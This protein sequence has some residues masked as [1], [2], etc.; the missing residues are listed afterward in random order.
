M[1]LNLLPG[2]RELRAPLAAGYLWLFAGWL[3]LHG[4][5]PQVEGAKSFFDEFKGVGSAAALTFAAYLIGSFLTDLFGIVWGGARMLRIGPIRGGRS[6]PREIRAKGRLRE[7]LLRMQSV[8][9]LTAEGA[10]AVDEVC[11]RT[12]EQVPAARRS[13]LDRELFVDRRYAVRGPGGLRWILG[14]R[15]SYFPSDLKVDE[16]DDAFALHVAVALVDELD[17]ARFRLLSEQ[18]DLFS[19]VDRLNAEGE[20]RLA[21]SAPLAVLACVL[22][23]MD[24]FAWFLALAPIAMLVILG[25]NRREESGDRLVYALRAEK[26]TTPIL[27]QIRAGSAIDTRVSE[28]AAPAITA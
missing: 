2:L 9:P 21:V 7:R 5:V 11:K 22:G 26:V 25:F 23:F 1:L 18:K 6:Y 13:E 15:V 14:R 28:P 10:A 16:S 3:A 4:H 19:E 17:I 8:V 20:F 24:H 12:V 27:E